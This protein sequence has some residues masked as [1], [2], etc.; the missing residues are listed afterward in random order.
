MHRHDALR[1]NVSCCVATCRAA[2]QRV[3]LSCNVLC[4]AAAHAEL[5]AGGLSAALRRN[6]CPCHTPTHHMLLVRASL[7][8]QW[9][10]WFAAAVAASFLPSFL[11]SFD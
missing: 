3:V 11:P 10:P 5:N 7:P 9:L 8:V 4:S 6:N 2:L 1:C